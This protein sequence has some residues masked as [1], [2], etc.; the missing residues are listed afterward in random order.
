MG[1]GYGVGPRSLDWI[2]RMRPSC[3]F[4]ECEPD[5]LAGSTSSFISMDISRGTLGNKDDAMEAVLGGLVVIGIDS[6]KEL[7]GMCADVKS[8][9]TPRSCSLV[10]LI[11]EGVYLL[12]WVVSSA[13]SAGDDEKRDRGCRSEGSTKG[14]AS[15]L[16]SS[17]GRSVT[18]SSPESRTRA[19][20]LRVVSSRSIEVDV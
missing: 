13:D 11:G 12:R 14:D 5:E 17:R 6:C 10:A 8:R 20:E 16:R 18:L 9:L 2:D 15:S 19:L 1:D 3:F 4:G 7:R